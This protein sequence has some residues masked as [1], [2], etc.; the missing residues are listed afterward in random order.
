MGGIAL[1]FGLACAATVIVA[2]VAYRRSAEPLFLAIVLAVAWTVGRLIRL[3]FGHAF[4]SDYANPVIDT[5]AIYWIL[6]NVWSGRGSRLSALVVV[7]IFGQMAEHLRHGLAG[8]DLERTISEKRTHSYALNV[9]CAAQLAVVF[10]A[11]GRLAADVVAGAGRSLL[12][13]L[14]LRPAVVRATT[15]QRTPRSPV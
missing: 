4:T 8:L 11:G 5:A 15:V 2:A 14:G 6:W 1:G 13:R 9:L 3:E 7:L 10:F 12:A